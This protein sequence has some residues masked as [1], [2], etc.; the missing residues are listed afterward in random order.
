MTW[1]D[2]IS[3]AFYSL[4]EDASVDFTSLQGSIKTTRR[5]KDISTGMYHQ[6]EP[7]ATNANA[8]KEMRLGWDDRLAC[9]E[10][11]KVCL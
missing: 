8:M 2:V 6:A 10:Y 9:V 4:F 3:Q 1:L 5:F 7:A 11:L